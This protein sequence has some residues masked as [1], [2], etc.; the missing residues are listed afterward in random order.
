MSESPISQEMLELFIKHQGEGIPKIN[1][2]DMACYVLPYLDYESQLMAIRDLINLH[3]EADKK[4]DHTIKEIEK[5]A[6][7][8][9]GLRNQQAVDDWV[10]HLHDSVYQSAAY[11]M[12]AVGMLAPLVESLFYQAFQGIREKF[13]SDIKT[14]TNHVRWHQPAEDQWDCHFVWAKGKRQTK[15]VEG[16]IQLADAI[17]LSKHL[18]EDLKK[19]LQALF[20]Y[21]NK[22]FHCG[23]EW[24]KEERKRF[25]N[26]IQNSK[27]DAEWFRSS[28]R[29]GEPWIF[30][31][32]EKFI[33]HCIETIGKVIV[34]FGTYC[35]KQSNGDVAI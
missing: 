32:T 23:F 33:E 10:D 2:R 20:E 30:Y 13:Y 28:T 8:S 26:R 34:G 5:Y 29:D 31:L 4:S 18:P 21:R 25:E 1:D 14:P 35:K 15:L 12:S 11:S 9:T 22:M 7:K 3:K 16:I 27:W 24:P 17:D 6:E 19:T